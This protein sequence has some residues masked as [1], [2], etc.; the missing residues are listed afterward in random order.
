MPARLAKGGQLVLAAI[1]DEMI[2]VKNMPAGTAAIEALS[3]C[4]STASKVAPFRSR[5]TRT[6]M[7]S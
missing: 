6:G 5:A 2:C 7:L 1:A 4:G 3:S